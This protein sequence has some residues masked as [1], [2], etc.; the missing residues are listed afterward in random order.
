MSFSATALAQ[1]WPRLNGSS[2]SPRMDEIRPFSSFIS[3]PQ[4]ASQRLQAR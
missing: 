4:I 2:L 3:M 1:M